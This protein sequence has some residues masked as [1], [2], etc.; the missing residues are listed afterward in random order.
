[1]HALRHQVGH[2]ADRR[3]DDGK[4]RRHRLDERDWRT[5]VARGEHGDVEVGVDVRE[6]RPPAEEVAAVAQARALGELYELEPALA[7]ANH[8]EVARGHALGDPCRRREE[9]LV[10]LDRHEARDDAHERGVPGN[11][12]LAAQR[13]AALRRAGERLEVEAERHHGHLVRPP[14]AER[15][16][17]RSHAVAHGQDAVRAVG[18]R[19]LDGEKRAR[20]RGREVAVEHVAV[21]GVH[22]NR[23]AG[24]DRCQPPEHPGLGGVRVDQ[25]RPLRA[26]QSDEVGERAQVPPHAQLAAERREAD[27]AIEREIAER[28]IV[29]LGRVGHARH[30]ATVV[31]L[32]IEALRQ[33]DGV[34]RR[35][36]DVQAGDDPEDPNPVVESTHRHG[37]ASASPTRTARRNAERSRAD[38][39]ALLGLGISFG[40]ACKEFVPEPRAQRAV[41]ASSRARIRAAA[42]A[43]VHL[44]ATSAAARRPLA[45]ASS[46]FSN[47]C[48]RRAARCS[49]SGSAHEKPW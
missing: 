45:A 1:M 8:D 42:C 12:E 41:I 37:L 22:A 48:R 7:V 18:E 38:P 14:D 3:R 6:V 27:E 5:L 9:H 30:E 39:P 16:E 44:R 19:A 13:P 33:Q 36:A 34:Q 2:A 21:E 40:P 32:G 24:E 47:T 23:D 49:G 28:E 46:R 31:A 35:P 10:R 43:H 26:Q 4:P 17:I 25:V 20:L 11:L 15:E 29:A